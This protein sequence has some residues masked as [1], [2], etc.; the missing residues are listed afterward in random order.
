MVDPQ[1]GHFWV[2]KWKLKK[3]YSSYFSFV[4]ALIT[5]HRRTNVILISIFE[6]AQ[7][8]II[9]CRK[10]PKRHFWHSI[11]FFCP[12]SK[13]PTKRTPVRLLFLKLN[14]SRNTIENVWG[15]EF[16]S[17]T[18]KGTFWGV[19]NGTFWKSNF[20]IVFLRLYFNVKG[21]FVPIFTKK[22]L[23]FGP[24]GIFEKENFDLCR[25]FGIGLIKSNLTFGFLTCSVR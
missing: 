1:K 19:Q 18:K 7:K 14:Q 16:S 21:S 13:I 4:L 9:T 12:F 6:N 11:T 8:N 15:G 17:K 23:K 20:K 24:L 3:K 5:I 10:W 25:K 22:I 2:L